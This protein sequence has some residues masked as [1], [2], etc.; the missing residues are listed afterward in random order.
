MRIKYFFVGT[1]LIMTTSVFAQTESN[2]FNFD[3]GSGKVQ[4][5]YI[6]VTSDMAYSDEV[7]Y[8]FDYNTSPLDGGKKCGNALTSDFCTSSAPFYFSVALP[9]GNYDVKVTLGNPK[10]TSLTTVKA[11][12]RRLMLEHIKTNKGEIVTKTFTV[13]VRSPKINEGQSIRLKKREFGYLNWDNK[14]TLEFG[15]EQACVS[16]IEI[17]PN[18]TATTIFLAGNSTVVDQDKEPWASWGQMATRFFAPEK[19]VVANF[20]ESGESL[21]SFKSARR[22]DKVLSLMKP[23]D[24]LFI[25]FGHNDQK[26]KGEENSAWNSY[27]DLFHEYVEKT[28]AKGG[29]PVIIT[30]MHRR[31]FDDE[32]KV[33]NTL[34]DFPAAARKAASDLNVPLVDMNKMSE[35]LYESW[36]PEKSVS[37]FVHYPANTW[38]GQDKKLEDNTHFNP[39]GAYEIAKCILSNIKKQNIGISKYISSELDQF[40][41]AKPDSIEDFKWVISP[42]ASNVKPDGN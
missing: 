5:G 33:I 26:H 12:S 20:A 19:V 4:K 28:R 21:M 3:F 8:G 22:L 30:S 9:E 7:G 34:G 31:N 2:T 27:T 32:G 23:G 13:N 17:K 10:G 35:A 25:E 40:E 29:I 36:G 37:A 15:D 1:L 16:S 24:Y 39:Y 38:P 6:Q 41:P 11:E 42:M 14:L 18:T